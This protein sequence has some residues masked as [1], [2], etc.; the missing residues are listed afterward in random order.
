MRVRIDP[1]GE[2]NPM[3]LQLDVKGEGYKPAQMS[4]MGGEVE[5][6]G[7][8]F[9]SK[10]PNS[11]Y[12]KISLTSNN[13]FIPLDFSFL[14][15][16]R[17]ALRVPKGF[18]G[19]THE[20]RLTSPTTGV[21]LSVTF[22][23]NDT[24]TPTVDLTSTATITPNTNS[25]ISLTRT[26]RVTTIPELIE[27]YSVT[28]PTYKIK[29]TGQTYS[30]AVINFPVNLKSGKYGFRLYDDFYGWF[31][32]T[33]RSFLSVS[34]SG[35]YTISP[36]SSSFNGGVVTVTGNHI[37]QGA[38]VKVNNMVGRLIE[39]TDTNAKFEIPKLV[40]V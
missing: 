2:S 37:G 9:P 8:G 34:Q 30:S 3:N 15:T 29:I 13:V 4:V 14:S 11:H 6:S 26:V 27:I 36:T 10:W 1:F 12:N 23:Q 16:K 7:W 25:V 33:E 28:D 19:K 5:I 39:R 32:T 17:I 35:T 20:F 18:H 40:T 24:S 21:I 31:A 22:V 38:V